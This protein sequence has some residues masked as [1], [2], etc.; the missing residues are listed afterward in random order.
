MTE[1]AR[2]LLLSDDCSRG[3]VPWSFSGLLD[4]FTLPRYANT[5]TCFSRRASLLT[6]WG[7]DT[8]LDGTSYKEAIRNGDLPAGNG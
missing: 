5:F 4:L 1:V 2:Q 8:D 6:L 3:I 7:G